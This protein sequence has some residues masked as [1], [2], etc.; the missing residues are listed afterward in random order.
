VHAFIDN[1][2]DELKNCYNQF[3]I[4]FMALEGTG[5]ADVHETWQK[6]THSKAAILW[7]YFTSVHL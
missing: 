1:L 6:L 5:R 2:M 3:K 7:G 4:N